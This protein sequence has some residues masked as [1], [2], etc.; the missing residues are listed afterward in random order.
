MAQREY[1]VEAVPATGQ[2]SIRRHDRDVPD[3][4]YDNRAAAES[5]ARV[6]AHQNE[7]VVVVHTERGVLRTDHR[8]RELAA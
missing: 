3:A 5:A 2:W 6:L 7:A 8:G 4:F 1:H